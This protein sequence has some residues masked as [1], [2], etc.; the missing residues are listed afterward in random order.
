ME[1]FLQLF[2]FGIVNGSIYSLLAIGFGIVYRGTGIFHIAFAGIYTL[3]SYFLFLFY[4]IFN[5]PLYISIFISLIFTILI[6]LLIE[7]FIYKEFYKRNS[8]KGAIFIASLGIYIVIENLIALLFGNEVKVLS[9]GVE[10]SYTIFKITFTRIEI[11]QLLASILI[12][13]LF[14]LAV[15]NFTLMKAIW[16]MGDE[17]ELLR[18][19]GLP[20]FK[21][22]E[23]VFIISSFFAGVASIL[24]GLDVGITPHIGMD[25]LLIGVVAII[26]GGVDSFKG[27]IFGS[28]LIGEIESLIII[29]LSHRWAPLATF[30]LLVLFI[31]LRP[32][33]IFGVKKRLEEV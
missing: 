28:F 20:L 2:F 10:P 17:P 31:L 15:K 24:K 23:Y 12:C 9:P 13:F 4:R 8:S 1:L 5:F 14:Y 33:G 22:R 30:L 6:G 32:Q 21:L 25:A 19:I 7:K 26:V 3:S 11:I 16:G 27:W 18:I 29:K